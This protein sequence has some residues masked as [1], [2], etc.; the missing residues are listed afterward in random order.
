[1]PIELNPAPFVEGLNKLLSEKHLYQSMQIGTGNLEDYFL[2]ERRISVPI[3]ESRG[4][5][6]SDPPTESELMRLRLNGAWD[7]GLPNEKVGH[8]PPVFTVANIKTFCPNCSRREAFAPKS[9]SSEPMHERL[10]AMEQEMV[11]LMRFVCQACEL[12]EVD[13]TVSRRKLKLTIVGRL[14]FEQVDVPKA[15]PKAQRKLYERA[16]LNRNAGYWLEST[17]MLRVFIEQFW[18]SLKLLNKDR[19]TG[20]EM[21]EAYKASIPNP[22]NEGFPSLMEAYDELSRAMHTAEAD[23]DFVDKISGNIEKHFKA[24]ELYEI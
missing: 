8:G 17:F 6:V 20:D 13:F 5:A 19:P 9:I 22:I 16:L 15:I 21:G 14:P 24:R 3:P 23:S 10:G 7:Y 4:Y 18:K 2:H 11:W 1:M 12:G